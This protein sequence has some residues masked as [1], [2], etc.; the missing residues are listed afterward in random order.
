MSQQGGSY[1]RVSEAVIM[2]TEENVPQQQLLM[3]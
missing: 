2:E 1:K 3:L